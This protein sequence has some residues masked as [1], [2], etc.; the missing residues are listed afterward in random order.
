MAEHSGSTPRNDPAL[1][2]FVLGGTVAC[3]TIALA[4]AFLA[5]AI[6]KSG[7]SGA[8]AI[9]LLGFGL[10]GAVGGIVFSPIGKAIGRRISGGA[11]ADAELDQDIHDL[12]LQNEELRQGL[13]EAQERLDFAERLLAKGKDGRADG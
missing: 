2:W 10:A 8:I 13:V 5:E 7:P 3:V 1:K 9:G 11:P 4:F 12:H 6:V